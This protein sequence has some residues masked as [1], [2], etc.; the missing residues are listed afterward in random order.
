MR[1]ESHIKSALENE[2]APSYC[3]IVNESDKHNVQEGSE[4]H[5]KL[6]IVSEKFES[7][8]LIERQ[9][10]VNTLIKEHFDKGLHALTMQCY[11]GKE[12]A[13]KGTIKPS[14][15]CRGGNGL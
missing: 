4:T 10:W 5:F 12:W 7:L 8:S 14:P 3:M 6:V 2:F 1:R 9:R 13:L 15:N 11:T